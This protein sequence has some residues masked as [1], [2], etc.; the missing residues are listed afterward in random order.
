MRAITGFGTSR[1]RLC[2]S[3]I[4]RPM[5]PRPL[6]WPSCEA[7]DWSPPVQ[8]ALSPAPVS[9][10]TEIERSHPAVWNAWISSSTVSARKALY[11]S[12]RLM[13]MRA[14]PSGRTS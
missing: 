8:K 12:G 2:N 7:E 13:V 1:M 4:G 14:T 3:S 5:V 10:I 9:T 11:L 6:Y